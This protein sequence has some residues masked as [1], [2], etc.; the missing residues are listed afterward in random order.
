MEF[1][2]KSGEFVKVVLDGLQYMSRIGIAS[3]D[4]DIT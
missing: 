2:R 3:M 4:N 1:L